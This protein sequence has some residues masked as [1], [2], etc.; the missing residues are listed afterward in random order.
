MTKARLLVVDDNPDER[1]MMQRRLG[2]LGYEVAVA[3]GGEQALTMIAAI[4]YDLVILDVTMPDID[5]MEVLR[6]LRAT[7]SAEQLPVIMVTASLA[8]ATQV[9]AGELGAN[10]FIVKPVIIEMAERWIEK[11]V[12]LK[13]A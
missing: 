12:N 7:H 8:M 3:E 5:G 11:L 10:H 6:R 9:T 13:A 4:P 2:K 1:D